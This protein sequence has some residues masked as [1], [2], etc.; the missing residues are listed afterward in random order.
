[1]FTVFDANPLGAGR[2]GM[3]VSNAEVRFD[4]IEITGQ[5][6]DDGGPGNTLPVEPHAKLATTWGHLK[7]N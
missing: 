3:G 2:T 4:D 7:N 6:I 5:N 1:M